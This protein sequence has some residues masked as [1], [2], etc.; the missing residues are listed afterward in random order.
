MLVLASLDLG[1]A[2]LDALSGFVVVWLHSMPIR[3][4]LDVN[5]WD[6]LP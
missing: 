6:A 3:P 4:S 2:T 1:F 5:T